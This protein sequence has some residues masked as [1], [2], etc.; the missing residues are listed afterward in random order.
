MDLPMAAADALFLWAETPTRPLHVGALAV[1][2]QPDNGTGR[3]LRKVFSAAVA[4]Q[5][6]APWWRRRPHR[7]LTSLGQWSWRTETEVDLDYH[8]RLSALPPRAGTAELWALVSELHAGML[9]RSRPLWQVDLIEGLPGG[10]CAVY[11]KVHHALADGV[12]VM[13]LLQ[14]IVTADPHQR[15]MP[16]LW[17]VPA[18]ASVAKHTAPRGSSRPLTL[19]KGVLGQARGVPGMVRVVADTTWRAAQCRSGPLT[20]AAPHTPLNEPIAGARSVA[21]CSFPIERLQQV[22]E[23]ADATINDVVLAMC[24]GALRAYLISRGALPGAPLIA[25]VPVS[26]RDT[27]VID[28]FGQGPGNKIGTLMCSLATHLA[29]PVERLSAIRAS[30][31]DG[32][33]AIA[34]RSRNQ[35][36]AMSALGAAPLA[37]AMA[38]GRVPAPLRP[39]NVTISNVPGPQGALYWN[40]ARLDALYLLSAPVDG[41]ALNITCSGTNE[42]ITFGLTGCRRAVPA[43]SIL[44]D[45]LAHELE[46]LVGVSEA[47]PGTRLRRIA[48]R[49]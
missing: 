44:T 23:H 20:L 4:R 3:Y 39:P 49:R 2:S 13:R 5:Q 7:S 32:K 10:R 22:A 6:V 9:D 40:G 8:V 36:L 14:R 16:T 35:A 33:A 41:A 37:L 15:Q 48:G 24:G 19:A 38:L 17:E 42:Q 12:S 34:G 29:S 28:V 46:L 21:G 31:R 1:L 25:M 30:M 18:Q 45:Q 26:L 11:V 47:G 43:L 27:A